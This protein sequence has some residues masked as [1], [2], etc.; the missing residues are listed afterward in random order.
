MK[1][2]PLYSR[3][4][5]R[6]A[7]SDGAP[8][9]IPYWTDESA[10]PTLRKELRAWIARMEARPSLR[11]TTWERTAQMAQAAVALLGRKASL[12][13][14]LDEFLLQCG[15]IRALAGLGLEPFNHPT[16][17]P[18]NALAVFSSLP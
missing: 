18:F 2:K 11:A 17:Q 6:R 9:Q 13:E 15:T 16:L 5:R 3:A 12:L 4:V 14:A 1:R 10:P 8:S 7:P